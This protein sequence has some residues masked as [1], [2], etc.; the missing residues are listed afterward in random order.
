[1]KIEINVKRKTVLSVLL[2]GLI[3]VG[4]G[5]VTAESSKILFS[6]AV[7]N[8]G[9]GSTQVEIPGGATL[10]TVFTAT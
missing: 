3:V 4:L 1:M 7:P 5:I 2:A 9:H 8:P 6:P 10:D